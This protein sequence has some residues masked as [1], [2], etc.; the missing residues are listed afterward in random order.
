MAT[1]AGLPLQFEPVGAV[2]PFTYRDNAT[3]LTIL[4]GM[5]EKLVELIDFINS[6]NVINNDNLNNGLGGLR[7]ELLKAINDLRIELTALIEGSHDESIAFDP[8]NGTR[9]EGLSTVISRV[10]DNLRI[11]AY[12]AKQYDDLEMTAAEYD[13]LQ[14]TARH[15][16]LAITHPTLNDVQA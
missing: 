9:L 7:T 13:A 1:L 16:D 12:F 10:Y 6:S 8:T 14:L 11:Y 15:Y 5:R 4:H 3:Y 2:Q